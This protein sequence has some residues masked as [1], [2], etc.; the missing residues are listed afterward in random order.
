MIMRINALSVIKSF[1]NITPMSSC[2]NRKKYSPHSVINNWVTTHSSC[3]FWW[4]MN[5]LTRTATY[6]SICF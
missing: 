3:C 4:D 5:S 6:H 1:K 2:W